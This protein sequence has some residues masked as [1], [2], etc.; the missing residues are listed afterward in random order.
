MSAA[1]RAT[2]LGRGA[3]ILLPAAR[4]YLEAGKETRAQE[5]ASELASHFDPDARAYA[6]LI[7]G[8]IKL[9]RGRPREAISD[10]EEARQISDTWPGRF[11]L[12][13]AYLAANAFP[14]ADA[15]LEA[16]VKSPRKDNNLVV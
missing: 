2:A 11:D 5:L 14:E 13:Q 6:K 8:E 3:N 4:I 1:D 16:C 12:G 15:E 10:F 9:R 7:G